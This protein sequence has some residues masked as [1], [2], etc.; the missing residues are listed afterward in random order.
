[1]QEK[2]DEIGEAKLNLRHKESDLRQSNAQ[3][4]RLNDDL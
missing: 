2:D 3:L 4:E 1:M